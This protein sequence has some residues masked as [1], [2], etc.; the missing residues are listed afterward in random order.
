VD[1]GVRLSRN[2]ESSEEEE[3]EVD[4]SLSLKEKFL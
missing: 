4:I 1:L 3:E 2:D